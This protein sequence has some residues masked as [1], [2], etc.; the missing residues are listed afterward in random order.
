[1]IVASTIQLNTDGSLD[2]SGD[3]LNLTSSYAVAGEL[4]HQADRQHLQALM[5]ASTGDFRL[6]PT[7]GANMARQINA[8]Q[9]NPFALASKIRSAIEIT[10]YYTIK[11]QHVKIEKGKISIEK[12]YRIK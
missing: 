5:E 7:W 12:L 10:G 11:P 9:P 1:M 3:T 2:I 6:S 8:P 4:F